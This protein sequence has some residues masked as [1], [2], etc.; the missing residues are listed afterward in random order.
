[1]ISPSIDGICDR[2]FLRLLDLSSDGANGERLLLRDEA[3]RAGCLAHE[4]MEFFPIGRIIALSRVALVALV[5]LV[6]FLALLALGSLRPGRPLL[7]VLALERSARVGPLHRGPWGRSVARQQIGSALAA[8]D[9]V[10][11]LVC[12][13]LVGVADLADPALEVHAG[14]LLNH[15]RGF[16]RR[17]VQIRRTRERDLV[18]GR[19]GFGADRAAR[20]L[21]VAADVGL[22]AA[23]VV[24]AEQPLDRVRM[25]Q[26]T[27]GAGYA[28]RRGMLDRV[29][30]RCGSAG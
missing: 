9:A 22:D 7:T 12:V 8:H 27:A 6:A 11:D 19:V 30:V 4:P 3:P 29:G 14:A 23:H 18:P 5:A 17:G 25:R 13:A 28:A 24:A 26:R 20:G 15:V 10:G 1:M 2:G 21:G 16:V